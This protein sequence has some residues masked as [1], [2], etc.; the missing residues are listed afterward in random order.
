[1]RID[2]TYAGG[3]P[4]VI[5]TAGESMLSGGT[6]EAAASPHGRGVVAV[7]LRPRIDRMC[8]GR[9][10]SVEVS[11]W[12]AR[13]GE[14]CAEVADFG[15][16]TRVPLLEY[17]VAWSWEVLPADEVARAVAVD[18]DDRHHVRRLG[19]E[20]MDLTAFHQLERRLIPEG[21]A[22]SSVLARRVGNVHAAVRRAYPDMDDAAIGD[23]YGLG[24]RLYDWAVRMAGS[25]GKGEGGERGAKG[26]PGGVA[27]SLAGV[28][29][30]IGRASSWEEAVG[31]V[32]TAIADKGATLSALT[33][34]CEARGVA[35]GDLRGLWDE[36]RAL[37]DGDGW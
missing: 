8:E 16:A 37:I 10:L 33:R 18:I 9:G 23:L 22:R 24:S 32:Y 3:A 12:T 27:D 35:T 36:A 6:L 29:D 19:G 11:C 7:M 4:R 30:A 31:V 21:E 28:A 15:H 5:E 20:L 13:S 14:P 26:S 2:V 17:H 34:A 1:M 25:P